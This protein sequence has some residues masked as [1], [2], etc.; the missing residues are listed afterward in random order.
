MAF[1]HHHYLAHP[2]LERL[3][4]LADRRGCHMQSC[5]RRVERAVLD[6]RRR[7]DDPLIANYISSPH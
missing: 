1:P 3:D 7:D 5:C 6:H 2:L 4:P